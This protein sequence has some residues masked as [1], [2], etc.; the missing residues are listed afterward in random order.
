[1]SNLDEQSKQPLLGT[2]RGEAQPSADNAVFDAETFLDYVD[3]NPTLA[4]RV[5]R[6]FLADSPGRLATIRAALSTG[7]AQKVALMA[8]SLKGSVGFFAAAAALDA[9]REVETIAR[10]GDLQGVGDAGAVLEREVLRLTAALEAFL[11]CSLSRTQ[12]PV[13]AE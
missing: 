6:R 13:D 9:A 12:A 1:M 7:D 8:H 5:V 11:A 10:T 4:D 3:N 2:D